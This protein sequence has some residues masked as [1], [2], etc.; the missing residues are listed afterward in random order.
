MKKI[1]GKVLGVVLGLSIF[2]GSYTI[3]YNAM[4]NLL[5]THHELQNVKSAV[6]TVDRKTQLKSISRSAIL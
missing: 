5:D 4:S 1:L 2:M 3:S 6:I